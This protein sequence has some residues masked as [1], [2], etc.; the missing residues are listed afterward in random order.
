M[1]AR[2]VVW[3]M[4]LDGQD[5]AETVIAIGT[6]SVVIGEQSLNVIK[7]TGCQSKAG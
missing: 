3:I 1:H 2:L 4:N 6:Y 5:A 7:N